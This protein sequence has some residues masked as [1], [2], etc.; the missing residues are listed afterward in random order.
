MIRVR[1]PRLATDQAPAVIRPKAKT[2]EWREGSAASNLKIIRQAYKKIECC[3]KPGPVLRH[4]LVMSD[5]QKRAA[6]AVAVLLALGGGAFLWFRGS[7][8]SQPPPA[9]TL[10]EVRDR[11]V[12]ATRDAKDSAAMEKALDKTLNLDGGGMMGVF[13]RNYQA[14]TPDQ[15][16]AFLDEQIKSTPHDPTSLPTTGPSGGPGGPMRI[17]R[18]NSMGDKSMMEDMSPALR[19]MMAEY[20]RDIAARRKELGL[21]PAPVAIR[22]NISTGNGGPP[23]VGFGGGG[24]NGPK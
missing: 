10:D 23:T 24:A 16:K 2:G 14:M 4:F 12:A 7:E 18:K 19:A 11:I 1:L 22:I 8:A 13:L 17:V 6:I 3:P 5:N 9:K 15:K 20:A 21:P